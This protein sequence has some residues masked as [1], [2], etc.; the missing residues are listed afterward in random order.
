MRKKGQ[1][2]IIDAFIAFSILSIGVLFALEHSR[3]DP[4]TELLEL[5]AQDVAT[6]ILEIKVS[7]V[8]DPVI[9]EQI[10]QGYITNT[11]NSLL[12][13][14]YELKF[15]QRAPIAAADFVDSSIRK[16]IPPQLNAEILVDGR[17]V[18]STGGGS[19]NARNIVSVKKLVFGS[20]DDE[21]F[22]GPLK[23]EVLMW[24]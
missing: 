10:R 20:Y 13:Q 5:A 18:Y 11:Q 6:S 14:A 16:L 1:Y 17:E 12:Q 3:A 2:M 9:K 8:N 24:E 23:A 19:R 21:D 15:Y 22:W 4:P 7:D